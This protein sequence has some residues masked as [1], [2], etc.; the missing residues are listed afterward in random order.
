VL[1]WIHH[2]FGPHLLDSKPI[3]F[4]PLILVN[5][6]TTI[7]LGVMFWL[8]ITIVNAELELNSLK[9]ILHLLL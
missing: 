3:P 9:L 7:V 5:S 2:R 1:T 6:A 8:N 4:S